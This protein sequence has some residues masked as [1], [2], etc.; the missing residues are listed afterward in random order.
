MKP[1]YQQLFDEAMDAGRKAAAA[2]TPAPM[3]VGTPTNP[4]GSDIDRTKPVYY[5]SSGVCGFAWVNIRPATSGFAKWLKRT[6][7]VKDTSYYGG[8]NL[9]IGD[10]GQSLELKERHAEAM[11]HVLQKAGIKAYPMSRMD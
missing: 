6:G 4:L 5:V 10:Y 11:A 9:W 7:K 8:Y 1:N 3:V 2:H